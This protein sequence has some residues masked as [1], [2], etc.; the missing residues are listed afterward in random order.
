M[1]Q[2]T[3]YGSGKEVEDI[4]ERF[5]ERFPQMFEGFKTEGIHFIKTE[6]K[7]KSK[8]PIN[9]RTVGYPFEPYVGRPYIVE[10]FAL[11]WSR[12]TQK[13]KNLAVFHVM[14][15]IPQGGFDP[16]SKYY[17]KKN[18]PEIEMFKLEFAATGGIPDWWDN[19]AA[20]DPMERTPEQVAESL[21]GVEAIPA[22]SDGESG[23]GGEGS[24]GSDGVTRIPVTKEDIENV[25]E[26]AERETVAV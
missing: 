22:D 17:A 16:Q 1:A 24:E 15:A 4:M 14:C 19:P 18:K 9:L 3:D 25:T 12:M 26:G 2:F 8:R 21:P 6:G 5:L 13:Q 23:D 20:C 7:K 11:F 10:V